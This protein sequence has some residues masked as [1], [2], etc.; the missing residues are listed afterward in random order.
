MDILSQIKQEIEASQEKMNPWFLRYEDYLLQYVN[1]DKDDSV[2]HVNTIYSIM[3]AAMAVEQSDTLNVVMMP[4]RIGDIGIAEATTELAKFDFDVM[5]MKQKNFQRNWDKW[6]FWVSYL[7]SGWW[8]KYDQCIETVVCDPM[9][10]LPDPHSDH[11]TKSRFEY[12]MR[13]VLKSEMKEEFGYKGKEDIDWEITQISQTLQANDIVSGLVTAWK[14]KDYLDVFD[15]FTY[16]EWDLYMVTVDASCQIVLREEIV[17]PISKKEEEQGVP[18]SRVLNKKWLSPK[19][20]HPCGISINDIASDKQLVNRVLL[21]LRLTDAKFST[22]GQMNLVNSRVVKNHA[23][24]S[25]PSIEPKWVVANVA[26]WDRLSDAVYTV[27][28]QSMIQDS[29]AISNEIN[30]IIQQDTGFDARTL[31]VQWDKSA[32]LG[33]V[34]TIQSNANL[35]LSLGIEIGNWGEVE[36]WRDMWYAGYI[37]YFDKKDTKFI[38]VTKWFGTSL[39]EFTYDMFLGGESYDFHVESKK[40]VDARREKMKANFMAIYAMM[41]ADPSTKEYEKVLLKRTAYLYNGF[42]REEAEAFCMPTPDE[43]NAREL[44]KYI[45]EDMKEVAG[46]DKSDVTSM[47]EDHYTYLYVFES[48][49]DTNVKPIYIEKRKKAIIL[50]KEQWEMTWMNMWAG[51]N[52]GAANQLVSNSMTQNNQNPSLTSLTQ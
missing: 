4:R 8:N 42:T 14:E 41:M 49:R 24:L 34:Q 18:M 33:E 3:Q 6:F 39:T 17:E 15:W 40:D 30:Q 23:E 51:G 16:Y 11:I 28:R 43:L 38:R 1:Q 32:T 37:Q 19:R 46:I 44:V 10:H 45:N 2:I 12:D 7:R 13:R 31:G 21:N 27:P 9:L 5:G 25:E 48:A 26:Q 50:Q 52:T 22:F 47:S 35:R 20:Y 36:F 29:Y